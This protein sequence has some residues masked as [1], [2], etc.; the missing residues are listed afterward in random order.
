MWQGQK[1]VS[2]LEIHRSSLRDL[3]SLAI[4]NQAG[5]P[6]E[7]DSRDPVE[8]LACTVYVKFIVAAGLIDVRN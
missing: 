2:W 4:L 3:S 7:E 1:T 8:S 5:R 6:E